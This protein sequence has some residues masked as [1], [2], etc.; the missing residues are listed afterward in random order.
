MNHQPLQGEHCT[1]HESVMFRKLALTVHCYG[2]LTFGSGKAGSW[3]LEARRSNRGRLADVGPR[4][5]VCR[6]HLFSRRPV[7]CPHHYVVL[8]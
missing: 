2:P 5:T 6:H 4:A 8:R 1:S 7:N 3:T